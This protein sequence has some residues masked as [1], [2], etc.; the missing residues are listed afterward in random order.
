MDTS[1]KKLFVDGTLAIL[2]PY[3]DKAIGKLDDTWETTDTDRDLLIEIAKSL[4]GDFLDEAMADRK[5]SMM[6]IPLLAVMK[7][8][9]KASKN[10]SLKA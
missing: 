3:I 5:T 2:I 4:L 6:M 7:K 9:M 1:E 8:K 10:G